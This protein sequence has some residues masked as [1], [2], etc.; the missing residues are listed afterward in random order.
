MASVSI[1]PLCAGRNYVQVVG[2]G[3]SFGRI[4]A[5]HIDTGRR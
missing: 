1:R 5:V 4:G 3:R 2:R